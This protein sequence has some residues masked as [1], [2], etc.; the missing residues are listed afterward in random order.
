MAAIQRST[1]NIAATKCVGRGGVVGRLPLRRPTID[2][3]RLG[4]DEIDRNI[5]GLDREFGDDLHVETHTDDQAV[6][7]YVAQQTVEPPSTLAESVAGGGEGEAWNEHDVDH[8]AVVG[9]R[10]RRGRLGYENRHTSR[11]KSVV[12]LTEIG[13]AGYRRER[14]DDPSGPESVQLEESST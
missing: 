7:P 12:H 14:H 13:F 4:D 11:P 9:C 2:R 10:S 8:R 1:A 6:R 5:V 3:H